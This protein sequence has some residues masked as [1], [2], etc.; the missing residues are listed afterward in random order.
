MQ[1]MKIKFQEKETM[2]VKQIQAFQT[3][4]INRL[5]TK[6]VKLKARLQDK[7]KNELLNQTKFN[8][9][10]GEFER[11]KTKW[12]E[13]V[14]EFNEAKAKIETMKEQEEVEISIREEKEKK[15]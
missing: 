11:M 5:K 15:L 9:K 8:E 3:E 1:E 6:M 4:K 13:K 10:I 2:R 7:V 14:S 12:Q